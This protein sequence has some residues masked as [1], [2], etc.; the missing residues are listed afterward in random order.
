MIYLSYCEQ[1]PWKDKTHQQI[2]ATN[3]SLYESDVSY[4]S[5]LQSSIIV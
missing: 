2:D 3:K 5:V 1:I 4:S